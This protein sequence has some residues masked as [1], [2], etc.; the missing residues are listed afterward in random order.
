ME[1]STH[2]PQCQLEQCCALESL[3]IALEIAI[4]IHPSTAGIPQRQQTLPKHHP[5]CS[6]IYDFKTRKMLTGQ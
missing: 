1:L 6:I 4:A 3:H 5:T 2:C